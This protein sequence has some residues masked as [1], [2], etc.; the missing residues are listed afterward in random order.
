MGKIQLTGSPFRGS[1]GGFTG[2]GSA[3]KGQLIP[4]GISGGIG[5]VAGVIPPLGLKGVVG[6]KVLG[7]GN[8]FFPVRPFKAVLCGG[9]DSAWPMSKPFSLSGVSHPKKSITDRRRTPMSAPIQ[10]PG[11]VTHGFVRV[12]AAALFLC[13]IKDF[14]TRKRPYSRGLTVEVCSAIP[15]EGPWGYRSDRLLWLAGYPLPQRQQGP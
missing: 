1:P 4:K 13:F 12:F 3:K 11:C 15:C 7:K 14:L 5:K 6:A 10:F 8:G 9:E 2:K